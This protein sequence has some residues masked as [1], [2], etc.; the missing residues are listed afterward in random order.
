MF[1]HD[2]EKVAALRAEMQ[3]LLADE[4]YISE[5]KY[6][7]TAPIKCPQPLR[8]IIEDNRERLA[9]HYAAT[10]SGLGVKISFF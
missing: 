4:L 7:G 10:L 6:P 8:A 1:L 2:L 3:L 5:R 9:Q